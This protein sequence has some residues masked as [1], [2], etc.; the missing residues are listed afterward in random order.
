MYYRDTVAVKPMSDYK[1]L[2][3]FGDGR[4][5]IFDCKPYRKYEFMSDVWDENVFSKV[6]V[7]HGTVMWPGGEDLCPDDLYDYSVE[8]SPG[9]RTIG[10]NG[11]R[12]MTWL[13]DGGQ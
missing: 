1:L 4:Q 8:V 11:T 12:Q 13:S 9:E 6:V 10:T 2:L 5:G 7:D 3:T